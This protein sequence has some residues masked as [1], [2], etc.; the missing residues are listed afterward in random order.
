MIRKI[1]FGIATIVLSLLFC[2][3]LM[4]L[5][6]RTGLFDNKDNPN[7]VWI[8]HNYQKIHDEIEQRNW[9]Y[10]KLNPYKF[11]DRIR[12]E[13]KKDGVKRI[14][15][16]GDSFVWGT[17]LPYEQT[18]NHK[19]EKIINRKHPDVEVLSW[20][21]PAWSTMDELSFLENHGLKYDIDLLIVGYVNNDPHMHRIE[22]KVFSW[23]KTAFVKVLK[24]FFPNAVSFIR[25][26]L[27]NFLFK[28]FNDYGYSNWVTNLHSDDNIAEY[29]KL[30]QD[31]AQFCH[32]NNI[33][34]LFV[35]TPSNH[36][37]VYRE[38]FDKVIPVLKQAG[39]KYL[40]LYPAT[41]KEYGHINIRQLWANPGD[42]HPGPLLTDLYARQVSNYIEELEVL[43]NT[44]GADVLNILSSSPSV[45]NK[46]SSIESLLNIAL[47]HNDGDVRRDA[48][49]S[50]GQFNSPAIENKLI[51]A[52]SHND[53]KVREAALYALS[54]LSSEKAAA[55]LLQ[56]LE[57]SSPGVRKSAVWELGKKNIAQAVN[58]LITVATSDN[59]KFVRRAALSVLSKFNSTGIADALIKSL[60]DDFFYNR[61]SAA[62][63]LGKLHNPAA[64]GPLIETLSDDFTEV[65]LAVTEALGEIRDTKSVDALKIVSLHDENPLVR[66]QAAAAIIKITGKE[67]SKYRRKLLRMWQEF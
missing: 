35:L 50:L 42:S 30:L 59:D 2:L 3:L 36:S 39:I 31:F 63:A 23:H 29:G 19:M 10:A 46:S 11:T 47:L 9:Q 8:P 34:L 26:Y 62:I 37:T 13:Q 1:A 33:K 64:V 57:D 24:Y 21:F 27:Y 25:S 4:E 16:L 32:S 38:Q 54:S 7:P 61:K 14:A 40:D 41:K 60:K 67:Y 5:T 49:N 66:D 45:H 6:L 52:L 22:L 15:V 28:Y 20:G 51:I 43:S 12:S 48:V 56:A 18:W 65:R 53:S 44:R 17:G 55:H 58:V